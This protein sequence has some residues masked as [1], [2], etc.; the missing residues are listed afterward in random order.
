MKFRVRLG[1]AARAALLAVLC[2]TAM[3]AGDARAQGESY[4]ARPVRMVIDSAPGSAID[5]MS[6]VVA[7]RLTQAWGQQV[8]I[9][10][11]PGGGG[12][13]ATRVASSSPPDGYTLYLAAASAFVTLPGTAA[14]LPLELPRD[15]VPIGFVSSQPMFFAA[16]P[17]LGVSTL[18]ELIALAKKRPGEISFA[19]TG[20]GRITHLS[21][22]LLQ[23]RAGIQLLM[24]PYTAGPAHA[25]NDIMGGRVQIVIEGYSGLAGGLQGGMLKALAVGAAERLPGFPDLP[26]VAETIPGLTAG[27]WN[28]LVA[29]VGTPDEIVNK[30]SADLRKV[31][32]QPEVKNKLATIGAFVRPMSPAEVMAFIQDEQQKWKPVIEQVAAKP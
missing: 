27:G 31:L 14:N 7:D 25:L 2:G 1:G 22:E 13:I 23:L 11:H 19:A 15:F 8:L 9:L 24:V 16:T 28:V 32:E 30:V 29:P 6:R 17:T 5:V 12:A 20:R 10:N 3:A 4:P 21:G 18:P 26:T